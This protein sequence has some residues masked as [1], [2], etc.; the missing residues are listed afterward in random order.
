MLVGP[1]YFV[2][3]CVLGFCF[4]TVLVLAKKKVLT[5]FAALYMTGGNNA[6]SLPG[7]NGEQGRERLTRW[8]ATSYV[9]TGA[10]NNRE[11]SCAFSSSSRRQHRREAKHRQGRAADTVAA[12]DSS[13]YQRRRSSVRS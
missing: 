12:P 5:I 2:L 7:E 13:S 1:Y 3:D 10:G 11:L 8:D 6:F 4:Q 9:S